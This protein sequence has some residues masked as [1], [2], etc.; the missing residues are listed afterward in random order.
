[1]DWTDAIERNHEALKRVVAALV[2]TAAFPLSR[3][4]GGAEPAG[5]SSTR[6]GGSGGG[7]G[8]DQG[9]ARPTLPR[10]LHRAVLRLLRPAEA[11]ARR[12]VIAAAQ[13]LVVTLPP[14][15]LRKPK[16]PSER[17][18]GGRPGAVTGIWT[19]PHLRPSR[20][21]RPRTPCLPLFDPLPRTGGVRRKTASGVPRVC[22]PGWSA[23]HPVPLK[24][25]SKGRRSPA[26]DDALDA[27][28]LALRLHALASALDDLPREA[29]R[30][31]RWRMRSAE[32]QGARP[33][34]I[35]RVWPLRPG[36]LLSL[37]RRAGLSRRSAHAVHEIL[38]DAD[39]L[40]ILALERPDTS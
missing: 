8:G 2:A 28:R 6:D 27:T 12:L 37:G 23:P 36:R 16:P 19:P 18:K 21:P 26:P 17:S 20:A 4:S 35:R 32:A 39:H 40:A 29:R 3:V 11:A 22:A 13:G 31:A 34:S 5:P 25:T 33:G 1:M 14:A 7:A 38:R 15:H 10:H 24:Q 9:C 30:F